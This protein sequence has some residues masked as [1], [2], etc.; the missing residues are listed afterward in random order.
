MLDWV[1]QSSVYKNGRFHFRPKQHST[2]RASNIELGEGGAHGLFDHRP[3][4]F[5][6]PT[7]VATSNLWRG[8][9]QGYWTWGGVRVI[10]SPT[11]GVFMSDTGDNIELVE[12][13]GRG[14]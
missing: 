8:A 6:F 11:A 1:A 4:A 7:P 12:G 10:R 3:R 13:V 2:N 5:L 9:G 14:Y